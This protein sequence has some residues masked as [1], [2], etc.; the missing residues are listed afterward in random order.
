VWGHKCLEVSTVWG[1]RCVR[2]T[3]AGGTGEGGLGC[4][5]S[6][7]HRA[8]GGCVVKPSNVLGALA[9]WRVGFA[10]T[11]GVGRPG[12]DHVMGNMTQSHT[13]TPKASWQ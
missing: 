7:S 5:V 4:T 1:R 10:G 8:Q 3:G 6:R 12:V 2:G 11:G 13:R 9:R